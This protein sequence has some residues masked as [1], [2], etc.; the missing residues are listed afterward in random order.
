[1]ELQQQGVGLAELREGN[2]DALAALMRR[3]NR[4][5]YRAARAVLRDAAEAEDV[6]Q[7]T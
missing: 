5:L 2:P 6:V 1:M 7:E 3:H 4:R